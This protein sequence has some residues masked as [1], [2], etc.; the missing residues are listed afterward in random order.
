VD[1][2][3]DAVDRPE[4]RDLVHDYVDESVQDRVSVADAPDGVRFVRPV[5]V[6]ADFDAEAGDAL[7]GRCAQRPAAVPFAMKYPQKK[8]AL[9][10]ESTAARRPGPKGS[11]RSRSHDRCSS[12]DAPRATAPSVLTDQTPHR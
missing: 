3:L 12:S 1:D 2:R 5:D 11:S 9:A 6:D 4:P 8:S 10:P 7:Q